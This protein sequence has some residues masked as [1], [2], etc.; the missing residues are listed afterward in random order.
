MSNQ[1]HSEK[2]E[3]TNSNPVG[4]RK[5]QQEPPPTEYNQN[6]TMAKMETSR[7]QKTETH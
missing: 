7:A 6:H 3:Q 1:K 5:Q 4:I 2:F